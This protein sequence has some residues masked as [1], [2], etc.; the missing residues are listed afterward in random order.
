MSEQI[1]TPPEVV[2]YP[3]GKIVALNVTADDY[4]RDYAADYHEWVRGCVI[5][6][7]PVSNTHDEYDGY[8][9]LLL[10]AYFAHNPIGVVKKAPFVMRLDAVGS[11]REPDLQIILKDNPGE[12]TETAMIGAA[13]ICIEIVSQ[14]SVARDYGDKFAEYEAAGVREYWLFDPIRQATH[15]HRLNEDGHYKEQQPDEDGYY[16]T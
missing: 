2:E 7:S 5:K 3:A 8:L 11:R 13:D 4:M 10:K 12:L 9:Y 16:S 14:E 15:F 6:M 1:M